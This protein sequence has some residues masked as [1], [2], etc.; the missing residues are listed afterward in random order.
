[1]APARLALITVVQF[2]ENMSDERTAD[3]IRSRIDLEYLLA[4]P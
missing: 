2:A 1:M 4:L 3:A